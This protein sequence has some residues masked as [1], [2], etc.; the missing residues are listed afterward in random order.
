MR[1]PLQR[2]VARVYTSRKPRLTSLVVENRRVGDFVHAGRT[3]FSIRVSQPP[4]GPK[5]VQWS[6]L[7]VRSAARSLESRPQVAGV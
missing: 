1:E 2:Y 4:T 7:K 3:A 6:R 5:A